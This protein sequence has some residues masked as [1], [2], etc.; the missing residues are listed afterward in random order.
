V[1]LAPHNAL[2][3]ARL[4]PVDSGVVFAPS[5]SVCDKGLH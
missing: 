5:R 4:P 2:A 1:L 3:N